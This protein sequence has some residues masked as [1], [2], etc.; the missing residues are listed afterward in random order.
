V[1]N[2]NQTQ[3]SSEAEQEWMKLFQELDLKPNEWAA[4]ETRMRDSEWQTRWMIVLQLHP[5]DSR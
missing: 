5:S 2:A 4:N 3:S 1:H